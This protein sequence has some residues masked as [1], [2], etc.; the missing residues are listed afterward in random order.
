MTRYQAKFCP[1]S[2]VLAPVAAACMILS[3]CGSGSGS[4][5]IQACVASPG[6]HMVAHEGAP[7]LAAPRAGAGSLRRLHGHV[8]PAVARSADQGKIDDNQ[9]MT[10]TVSLGLGNEAGLAQ[11]LAEIYRPGSPK[12]HQFLKPEEFRARF[13]P[14][15]EQ[16]AKVTSYLE[17]QGLHSVTPDRN[18]LLVYA[19]G[20]ARALGAAFNTE[21]HQYQDSSGRSYRA[22]GYELQIPE[23][24]AIQ[25]VHGLQDYTRAHNHLVSSAAG[26]AKG[27]STA[28]GATGPNG[29]YS[30]ADIRKA[31]N[32]PSSLDGSGQTLAVFELDGYTAS[33]VTAYEQK[34]GLSAVPLQNVLVDGASGSAGGGAAEVTLDVELMIAVAPKASKILV[35]EGPNSDQGILDTYNRIATDNLAKSVST[36]WGTSEDGVTSSFIQ[37][38]NTIFMQ[39]AAQGQTIY[40]AAG[41]TG[42][43]D[44]GSTLSVDD[45]SSQPYVVAVGGTRLATDS[46]GTYQSET[47]WNDSSG[48]GGG[49]ISTVWTIPTWQQGLANAQNK[50][51]STMRNIPDVALHSDINTGYAIYYNGGWGNWGGTSC[52]APL[53][54]AFNALVN[55]QRAANGLG[56]LG[57]VTPTLYQLGKSSR[58]SADF[59]DI[60]DGSTNQYYPAV[61]GFDDATG[62]GSFNASNL[63]QDLSQ[64]SLASITGTDASGNSSNS[65]PSGT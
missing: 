32:V 3:G 12:F 53:W 16:I 45:P 13:S 1:Q 55:Q 51:S 36:S 56:P 29:G 27:A 18:G 57:Y 11:E 50:V 25:G 65:C 39:M 2:L 49:G 44:N 10:V 64:A 14:T 41:D 20:S 42:A 24:L 47:T 54:A 6:S 43:K 59:F 19:T 46:S 35:Y 8:L 58:A 61:T 21:V 9:E 34:F 63:L 26:E 52:A 62:W 28:R 22:P 15:Q 60:A 38:E 40:S 31:Y 7:Q 4:P 17:Q 23:G 5:A 48:A 37:A 33:D 30:P